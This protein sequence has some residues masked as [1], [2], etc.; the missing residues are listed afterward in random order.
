MADNAHSNT[1]R[2]LTGLLAAGAIAIVPLVATPGV[3]EAGPGNSDSRGG[4]HNSGASDRAGG[5]S[6]GNNTGYNRDRNGQLRWGDGQR[7]RST[8]AAERNGRTHGESD[9]FVCRAHATSCGQQ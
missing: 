2:V 8:G 7:N 3:A 4:S 5:N 6:R 9:W 1:R